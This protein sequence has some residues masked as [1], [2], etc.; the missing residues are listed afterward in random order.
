MGVDLFDFQASNGEVALRYRYGRAARRE[1]PLPSLVIVRHKGA[2]FTPRGLKR[3]T[4]RLEYWRRR[5]AT[6]RQAECFYSGVVAPVGVDA[7]LRS[8]QLLFAPYSG[9][10]W[11]AHCRSAARVWASPDHGPRNWFRASPAPKGVRYPYALE[12]WR[13]QARP[14]LVPLMCRNSPKHTESGISTRGRREGI[15]ASCAAARVSA[16]SGGN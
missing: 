4:P 11:A 5:R 14:Y 8:Q 9:I 16:P 13:Q 7:T 2:N 15:G 6:W 12:P 10:D 1:D 3:R